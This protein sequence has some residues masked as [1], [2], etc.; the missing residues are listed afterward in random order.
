MD[1]WAHQRKMGKRRRPPSPEPESS[2]SDSESECDVESDDSDDSDYVPSDES[3]F[4]EADGDEFEE[5][6]SIQAVAVATSKYQ[7]RSVT[8]KKRQKVA[9]RQRTRVKQPTPPP[10]PLPF[11]VRDWSSLYRLAGH[12]IQTG[13]RYMNC[14][15]LAQLYPAMQ[16]ID[17]LVGMRNV[18]NV[19]ADKIMYFLM[20]A[21]A[22]GM[23]HIC[24]VGPSGCGKTTLAQCLADLFKCMGKLKSNK[25]VKFDRTNAIGKYVG[26]TEDH[27]KKLIESAWGGCLLIDEAYQFGNQSGDGGPDSFSKAAIDILNQQL[28][29]NGHK[30]LCIIAG[31]ED[32][33]DRDFFSQ[34]QGLSRRFPW[35]FKVEKYTPEELRLIFRKMAQDAELVVDE[36]V[37]V[38]AWFREHKEHFS[39]F[40]GS[41]ENLIQKVEVAHRARVFN[42]PAG[43]LN[44]ISQVDMDE[45]MA[46]FIRY[47][48]SSREKPDEPPPF[49]YM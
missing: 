11:H 28:S 19:I 41:M 40:G 46:M 23:H 8:G 12:V 38:D 35:R 4:S 33:L 21:K 13:N 14:D 45:G 18:K 27:V 30:F 2:S 22:S 3:Q 42:E 31:Y 49:M 37:G 15:R 44:V 20:S 39:K 36:T 16:K 47:E 32:S 5:P 17:A 43:R 6:E 24:L 48:S 29:E 26:H 9:P 34:N 7:L 1:F 25:I 10:A